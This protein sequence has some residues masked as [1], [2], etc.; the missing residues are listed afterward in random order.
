[1]AKSRLEWTRDERR[2]RRD[3]RRG[4][5]SIRR[6]GMSIRVAGPVCFACDKMTDRP[7]WTGDHKK[8]PPRMARTTSHRRSFRSRLARD[9][10]LVR[11]AARA[12]RGSPPCGGARAKHLAW[13]RFRR[14]RGA[15]S[16]SRRRTPRVRSCESPAVATLA[17]SSRSRPR[18]VLARAPARPSPRPAEKAPSPARRRLL[19][20][21]AR[22]ASSALVSFR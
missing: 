21:A 15:L 2:R 5:A 13:E 4:R 9:L 12:S 1:M 7:S 18:V 3:E 8:A 17:R 10:D 22:S 16:T 20:R 14:A 11:R 6:R 19:I